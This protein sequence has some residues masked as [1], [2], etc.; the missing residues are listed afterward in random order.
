MGLR[1]QLRPNTGVAEK[2]VP[3]MERFFDNPYKSKP[4]FFSKIKRRAPDWVMRGELSTA[5]ALIY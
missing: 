4:E 3:I 1:F 2:N 5:R